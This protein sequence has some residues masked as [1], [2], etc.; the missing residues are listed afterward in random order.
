MFGP[1]VAW[2]L[3]SCCEI[4]GTGGSS[5]VERM[6]S[7]HEVLVLSP[8]TQ[9]Y[10]IKAGRVSVVPATWLD[11]AGGLLETG[12]LGPDGTKRL[13]EVGRKGR[14]GGGKRRGGE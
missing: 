10:R 13:K 4:I 1:S 2:L 7:M 14:D 12:R 9:A 3:N 5:A 8:V 6:P 11:E